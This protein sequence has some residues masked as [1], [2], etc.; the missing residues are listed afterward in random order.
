MV[1][2]QFKKQ[3]KQEESVSLL[4]REEKDPAGPMV[5]RVLMPETISLISV[6]DKE[7]IDMLKKSAGVYLITKKPDKLELFRALKLD[8]KSLEGRMRLIYI[9][10]ANPGAFK[11]SLKPLL[12]RL[13]PGT[14][15]CILITP[16]EVHVEMARNIA[17]S[18]KNQG[19]VAA[20]PDFDPFLNAW[21]QTLTDKKE[22]KELENKYMGTSRLAVLTR[23]MIYKASKAK[24]HVLLLGETGTGKNMI[25]SLIH[26]NS[27]R[28]DGPFV[29]VNCSAVPESLFESE[30]F[31]HRK[32]A[33]TNAV[34]AMQGHFIKADK[35][36]LFLD[37]IGELTQMNQAK[38]LQAVESQ[39][40][41]PVG[42]SVPS[43][44]D[45][46]IIAATNVNL[47]FKVTLN[48]FRA[49]LFYR[50]NGFQIVVPP[51]REHPEDLPAIAESL[52]SSIN[53]KKESLSG[54]FL[55]YLQS[56]PWPG[57]I[58]ELQMVL[59][60]MH[61]IFSGIPPSQEAVESLRKLRQDQGLFARDEARDH[62]Q[63]LRN[64]YIKRL[65]ETMNI[66]RAIRVEFRP[67]INLDE[68]I[69]RNQKEIKRIVL[70]VQMQNARLNDFLL[71]PFDFSDKLLFDLIRCFSYDLDNELK[72]LR[73]HSMEFA[74]I[75]HA[76]FQ[77][78][79]DEI[80]NQIYKHTYEEITRLRE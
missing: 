79:Y 35:G 53:G 58:R 72:S 39:Q 80:L 14:P 3:G 16:E 41:Y 21:L 44:V 64:N 22:V 28:K 12:R 55:Q 24:S 47:P 20:E 17:L 18:Q 46:R 36:T 71:D 6:V 75:W 62:Y 10:S 45:V 42:A 68:K 19:H 1:V 11:R 5:A 32:G 69:I 50:L 13:S 57:N 31:G 73:H 48:S 7:L 56:K 63:S 37:E 38:L 30:F 77:N 60:N 29:A 9:N 70:N 27:S 52:W 25:A 61:E 26:E 74:V 78:L 33:F 43:K 4:T 23:A 49:D 76:K 67:L 15:A 66:I 65:R 59:T 2:I 54:T 8:Y 34:E 51:I 40:F